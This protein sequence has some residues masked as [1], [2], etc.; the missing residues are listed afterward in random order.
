MF[1]RVEKFITLCPD[2]MYI[3]YIKY[4]QKYTNRAL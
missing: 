3:Y 4:I 1:L 2:I